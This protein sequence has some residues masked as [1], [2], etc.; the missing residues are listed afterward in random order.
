MTQSTI[1]DLDTLLDSTL[2]TVADIPDYI[3]PPNGTY[4]LGIHDAGIE[5]MDAREAS[6][7]KPA[8]P[9][10]SRIKITYKVVGTVETKEPPVAD[11]TLFTETFMGTEEGLGFFK[12]QVKK[13]M[14]GEDITGVS[15]RDLLDGLKGLEFDAVIT[16]R[17]TVSKGKTYENVN[18]RP[19]HD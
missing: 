19:I 2:D 3:N 5:K 15:M 11:G 16:T 14:N 13:I 12:K 18:V 10:G 1:L 8:R 6:G 4:R 9:A 17:S 7:D